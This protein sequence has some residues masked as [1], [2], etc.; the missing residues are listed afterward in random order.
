MTVPPAGT[1]PSGGA[2]WLP[3]LS[4]PKSRLGQVCVKRK[5][6]KILHRKKS[7]IYRKIRLKSTDFNRIWSEC[8]DLNPR[9]LGPE[10]SAI[11]NFATPRKLGYYSA[12]FGVCQGVISPFP[13]FFRHLGAKRQAHA[14]GTASN[15]AQRAWG[16]PAR[17]SQNALKCESA[18]LPH[19]GSNQLS[20]HPGRQYC[21]CIFP[22]RTAATPLARR[23]R[24]GRNRRSRPARR[25]IVRWSLPEGRKN[26]LPRRGTCVYCHCKPSRQE[27][28]SACH[29]RG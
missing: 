3:S 19:L 26:R 10:P 1:A 2:F 28:T 6:H 21:L 8:R 24:R 13:G 11:P 29:G 25:A 16:G 14:L 22:T 20:N 4:A 23:R 9:P 15:T 18:H 27:T 17:Q 7:R 12:D 5:S